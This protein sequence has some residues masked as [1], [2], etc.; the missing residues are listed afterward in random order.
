MAERAGTWRGRWVQRDVSLPDFDSHLPSPGTRP[1]RIKPDATREMPQCIPIGGP[2][3]NRGS[4]TDLQNETG[5]S[6][7]SLFGL[8]CLQRAFNPVTN[9]LVPAEPG[10]WIFRRRRW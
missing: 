5:R 8:T 7:L 3:P 1:F 4:L 10:I 6:D 9:D 2:A